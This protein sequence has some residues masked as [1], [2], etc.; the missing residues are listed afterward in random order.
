M[1]KLKRLLALV[2]AMAMAVALAMPA[3]AAPPTADSKG[4]ITVNSPIMGAEY[5][6]YQI[7]KMTLDDDTNPTA[8]SYSISKDDPF[9]TAVWDYTNKGTEHLILTGVT[10]TK[11]GTPVG[12][13]EYGEY[14]VTA[15]ADFL[16]DSTNADVQ[17]FGKAM[18]TAY[19]GM[20]ADQKARVTEYKPTYE[21]GTTEVTKATAEAITFENLPYGYYLITNNYDDPSSRVEVV[22][23]N[24]TDGEADY[25]KETLTKDSTTAEIEAA[26]TGYATAKYPDLDAAKAY[27]EANGDLFEKTWNDM[28]NNERQKVLDDLRASTK[29]DAIAKVNAAIEAAKSDDNAQDG[30]TKARLIFIDSTTPNGVINEKNEYEKWDVPVNPDGHADLPNI[31]EH[32][33]PKGGKNIIVGYKDAP[34]NKEPIYADTAEFAI[35]DDVHYQLS[36]NAVN[37]ERTE[38]NQPESVK[39]IKEYVIADYQ[40]KNMVFDEAQGLKVTIVKKDRDGNAVETLAGPIDYTK[41]VKKGYFFTNKDLKDLGDGDEV[42]GKGTGGIVIP[43]VEKVTKDTAGF[44]TMKNLT[45]NTVFKPN[46]EVAAKDELADTDKVEEWFKN[47]EDGK[48]YKKI[49]VSFERPA[50]VIKAGD[51]MIINGLAYDVEEGPK[52]TIDG[53]VYTIGEKY[54]LDPTGKQLQAKTNDGELIWETE[55]VYFHS[56][57]PDDVTILVDYHMTLTD[58]ATIDGKGNKNFSQFGVDYV[59]EGDRNYEYTKDHTPQDNPPEKPKQPDEKKERDDATVKTYAIAI[60]KVDENG[61]KL[62]GAEFQIRGVKQVTQKSD[63]WYKVEKYDHTDNN[64][65]QVANLKTDKNGLLVVDGFQTKWELDVME[66]KAPDGYNRLTQ[67]VQVKPVNTGTDATNTTTTITYDENGEVTATTTET[68][69]KKNGTVIGKTVKVN[70]QI[71][72][73]QGE[74]TKLADKAAFDALFSENTDLLDPTKAKEAI[75]AKTDAAIAEL[76]VINQKGTELPSTG[77]IGTTI[78]YVVG[79]ILVIG[80][81]VVLITKRRMDA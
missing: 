50:G 2:I 75:V 42:F 55:D 80:A 6:A 25:Y 49:P 58:T 59:E 20:T 31:P 17:A 77:G 13:V 15:A 29:A 76:Q 45:K 62:V 18:Q 63:G 33:E 46:P 48:F 23:E 79:A 40:N 11:L 4:T 71:T 34:T 27:V 69:Y 16:D 64:Y 57:Y 19:N 22:L 52:V 65:Y 8:F 70:N 36:I 3:M 74:D 73:Y 9:F 47:N 41:W 53:V 81:G 38:G 1:K 61:N 24:G 60:K 7:F 72:Y 56:L 5:F 68:V 78:F 44:D 54:L 66:T 12:D 10:S 35:G 32:D 14:T 67:P 39:Q 28:S 51:K 21:A 26:A 37:F 43:W 30:T